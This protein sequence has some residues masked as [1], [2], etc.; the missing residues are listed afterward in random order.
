MRVT[1]KVTGGEPKECAKA[2]FGADE[3][4]HVADICRPHNNHIGR[5]GHTPTTI[6]RG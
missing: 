3:D 4:I 2:I 6:F 5:R 1:E